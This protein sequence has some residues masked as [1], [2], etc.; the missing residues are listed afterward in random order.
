MVV[1]RYNISSVATPLNFQLHA[2][3]R[4]GTMPCHWNSGTQTFRPLWHWWFLSRELL[5][6]IEQSP[7]GIL[8]EI[9]KSITKSIGS[10]PWGSGLEIP[11]WCL[12]PEIYHVPPCHCLGVWWGNS[13]I[14]FLVAWIGQAM[15]QQSWD[16]VRSNFVPEDVDSWAGVPPTQEFSYIT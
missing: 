11:L 4:L 16:Q 2:R 7:S 3:W 1:K 5:K 14:F 10:G 9:L 12:P 8:K 6:R 15:A 13:Q